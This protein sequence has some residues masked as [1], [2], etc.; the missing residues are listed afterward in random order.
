M[1]NVLIFTTIAVHTSE[2]ELKSNKFLTNFFLC[3]FGRVENKK[4]HKILLVR[5]QKS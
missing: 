1:I 4:R 5:G 2:Q 3:L